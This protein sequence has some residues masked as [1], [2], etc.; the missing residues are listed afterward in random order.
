MIGWKIDHNNGTTLDE[1]LALAKSSNLKYLQLITWNDFG[2]GTMF[3]PTREFG[4]TYIEKVKT[5]AAVQ[6]TG[7]EFENISELYNLRKKFKGNSAVQKKLDQ[8][9]QYFVSL[10]TDKANTLL[11]A[12]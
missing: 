4:Y 2:E 1:T 3:E 11:Q 5:F 12:L 6:N 10:Q 8:V 9:F 7:N